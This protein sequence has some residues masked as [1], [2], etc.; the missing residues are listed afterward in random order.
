M[1]PIL[2][3]RQVFLESRGNGSP[4]GVSQKKITTGRKEQADLVVWHSG[5]RIIG[6][7]ALKV[8]N[9]LGELMVRPKQLNRVLWHKISTL[10]ETK[11]GEERT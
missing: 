7:L 6:I 4:T 2:R 3:F 10:I 1:C 8:N 9:K 11:E 5:E